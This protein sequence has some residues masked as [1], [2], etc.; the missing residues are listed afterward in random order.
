M[1]RLT[2]TAVCLA[3]IALLCFPATVVAVVDGQTG[4][5]WPVSTSLAASG[6]K[7]EMSATV[8]LA[9]ISPILGQ[10]W[11]ELSEEEVQ[12]QGEYRKKR[13]TIDII[14]VIA[15]GLAAWWSYRKWRRR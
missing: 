7:P 1:G 12:E 2:K 5:S 8:T 14:I 11:A 6:V 4:S 9:N 13:I 10:D 15:A 3:V